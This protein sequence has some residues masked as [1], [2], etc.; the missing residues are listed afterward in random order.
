MRQALTRTVAVLVRDGLTI[1]ALFATMIYLD[2][3]LSLIALVILPL[4][5]IPISR[6]GS[7]LRRVSR[8]TQ[9]QTGGMASLTSE[10]FDAARVVKT[11]RL[12]PL[13]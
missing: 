3:L 6:I 1:I 9:E 4:A 13:P 10:T 12:E 2:W 11:Y 7:R 5:L 8:T